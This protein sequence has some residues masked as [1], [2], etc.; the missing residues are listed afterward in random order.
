MTYFL[1]NINM[2]EKSEV[3]NYLNERKIKDFVLCLI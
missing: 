2:K 1:F 3:L